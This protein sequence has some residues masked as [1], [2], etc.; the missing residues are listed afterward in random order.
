M[1]AFLGT[2]RGCPVIFKIEGHKKGGAA[3]KEKVQ[4]I[5]EQELYRL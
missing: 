2:L 4:C 1:Y 5:E 3:F